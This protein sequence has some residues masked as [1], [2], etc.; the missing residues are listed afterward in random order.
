MLS[1]NSDPSS[2][3]IHCEDII[4]PCYLHSYWRHRSLPIPSTEQEAVL[5]SF[6]QGKNIVVRA[7]AG[8]G[9]TTTSLMM[10][11]HNACIGRSTLLIVYNRG[12]ADDTK[13][14]V[15]SLS[16]PDGSLTV[17]TIH[18][19]A[20]KAYSTKRSG[21]HRRVIKT[22]VELY[23]YMTTCGDIFPED[24]LLFRDAIGG[25]ATVIVDEAQDLTAERSH[26]IRAFLHHGGMKRQLV[27]VGDDTQAIYEYS[28]TSTVYMRAPEETFFKSECSQFARHFQNASYRFG[29]CIAHFVQTDIL[30]GYRYDE[31]C[32]RAL[33][34][35]NAASKNRKPEMYIYSAVN[36]DT[37]QFFANLIYDDIVKY[38]ITNVFVLTYSTNNLSNLIRGI[39]NQLAA[40]HHIAA[41]VHASKKA[42]DVSGADVSV[43]E[44]DK[45]LVTSLHSSKG[46]EKQAAYVFDADEVTLQRYFKDWY[47]PKSVPYI[48]HVG[49]TRAKERLVLVS[50]SKAPFLRSFDVPTL[51]DRVDVFI[52]LKGNKCSPVQLT[53]A[54]IVK[55]AEEHNIRDG[56]SVNI[57]S[58]VGKDTPKWIFPMSS[59]V[60]D[61]PL[62]E[63]ELLLGACIPTPPHH[64]R[65]FRRIVETRKYKLPAVTQCGGVS[66]VDFSPKVPTTIQFG[67]NGGLTNVSAYYGIAIHSYAQILITGQCN[68]FVNVLLA[69]CLKTLHPISTRNSSNA[70]ENIYE[71]LSKT[72][73]IESYTAIIDC[74]YQFMYRATKNISLDNINFGPA[75]FSSNGFALELKNCIEDFRENSAYIR[76]NIER[77]VNLMHYYISGSRKKKSENNSC[78]FAENKALKCKLHIFS[79]MHSVV[80]SGLRQFES[81]GS[82]IPA[83][84][85]REFLKLGPNDLFQLALCA[86]T[87]SN[88][89][90]QPAFEYFDERDIQTDYITL[91]A[92]KIVDELYRHRSECLVDEFGCSGV[93]NA[94]PKVVFYSSFEVPCNVIMRHPVTFGTEIP[95]PQFT[96]PK[97]HPPVEENTVHCNPSINVLSNSA[98]CRNLSAAVVLEAFKKQQCIDAWRKVDDTTP[99]MPANKVTGSKTMEKCFENLSDKCINI[100]RQFVHLF[101]YSNISLVG[102]M[103]YVS[104]CSSSTKQFYPDAATD[105][106][107]GTADGNNEP[108][109][110]RRYVI[111]EF[112]N[113]L[114]DNNEDHVLQIQTY[115]T[116][117]TLAIMQNG[118]TPL[119]FKT[120]SCMVTGRVLNTVNCSVKEYNFQQPVDH[121][122]LLTIDDNDDCSISCQRILRAVVSSIRNWNTECALLAGV[123]TAD[124]TAE[125]K[126]L[127]FLHEQNKKVSIKLL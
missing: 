110:T 17:L 63:K 64:S 70:T 60:K 8:A 46:R 52:I 16:F 2:F 15:A 31:A 72:C 119:S 120:A 106:T 79:L 95:H 73:P 66:L 49:L 107:T 109:P 24:S 43:F 114:D 39:L 111:Y 25:F 27:L 40:Q 1:S 82:N 91:Q 34:G 57:T 62:S 96:S 7:V 68:S 14:R 13:K 116:I 65:G 80:L 84:N 56:M 122:E 53:S 50:N 67:N 112:K 37:A 101:K 6:A 36:L 103:D 77:L 121:T 83:E 76:Y 59:I 51:A 86:D 125:C 23:N 44:I 126:W 113:T 78:S 87:L 11:W 118:N 81:G 4:S 54:D 19:A 127:Q 123:T 85:N 48:F 35:M 105:A 55:Y 22:D 99:D 94:S 75:E 98:M 71:T 92:K 5:T 21:P 41:N 117:L 108:P 61:V 124:C 115:M 97:C 102:R 58:V 88:E 89:Y 45:L 100:D 69:A 47:F 93:N 3:N 30:N 20:G 18:S 12:L 32:K 90:L 26:L 104:C 74:T 9:K 38:G 33:T 28:G 42:P 10:A 29:Q